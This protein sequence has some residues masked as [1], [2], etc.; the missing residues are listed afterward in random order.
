MTDKQQAGCIIQM[1]QDDHKYHKKNL[2]TLMMKTFM[3]EELKNPSTERVLKFLDDQLLGSDE[4]RTFEAY[5]DFSDCQEEI[6]KEV[7]LL[8]DRG[9]DG[10]GGGTGGRSGVLQ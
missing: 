2:Q 1:I 7:H 4:E 9:R 8:E 3:A 10:R 6:T 5:T